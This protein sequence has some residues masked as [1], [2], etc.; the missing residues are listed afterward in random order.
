M[1]ISRTNRSAKVLM[2]RSAFLVIVFVLASFQGAS[3]HDARPAYMQVTEVAPQRYEIIWRTPVLSGMRLPVVLRFPAN[4]RNVTEPVLRELSDSLVERR[5]VEAGGGLTGTRIEIV[6]LQATI[7]DALVRVQMLDG[8]YSTT[9]V[10]PS[11]PWI[12]IT[13]SRSS[14][15]VAGAYVMHGI[16]HIL[17]GYDHLL[18]VLALILIVRSTRVLLLTVTAFTIA[19]SITLSLATLG[20]VH[21]AGPPVEATIALSILLLACEIIRSEQGQPSLTAKWPWLVAFSFGLLHGFGFAS[22]L[23]EI[24]LPQG[25]IPLALFSFNVGVEIGQ[26]VFIAVVFGIMGCAKLIRLPA[27]FAVRA[28]PVAAYAIGIMAAYWF[29]ERLAGFAT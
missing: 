9:L 12:D 4:T 1:K 23:S 5:I 18:F 19:H 10:R 25:D 20:V 22:A 14:L 26:L 2:A 17:F 8:S 28:R 3:A 24:G 11:R 16:E 21:V 15:E 13:T 7:T 6:G 29:I 27:V